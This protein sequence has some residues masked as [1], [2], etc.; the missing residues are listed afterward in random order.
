MR[1]AASPADAFAA[2]TDLDRLPSYSPE[3]VRCEF[4]G[5]DATVQVGARFRGHNKAGDYEWHADCVVT[6]LA[7]DRS[8]AYEV[9]PEFEFATTWRYTVEPDGDGCIVTETFHAPLLEQPDI[10]PGRIEGRRDHLE[11][12]CER[13]LAALKADL[14]ST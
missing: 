4:L 13:T 14:E 9:P 5:D 7:P 6:E 11:L 3:N 8:F 10:Y 12:G 2:L 1:I